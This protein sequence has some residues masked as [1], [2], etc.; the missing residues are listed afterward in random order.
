MEQPSSAAKK[1]P[2]FF[3]AIVFVLLALSFISL[4]QTFESFLKTGAADYLTIILSVSAI[5][6]SSYMVAQ[7]RRK[8]LKLGF[9]PF[10]VFT[11]VQ[12]SNCDFKNT[13]EF[14]SGDFIL[15]KAELCPKCSIPTFVSSIYRE[16]T[17]EEKK[18]Q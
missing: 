4:Y 13:R 11:T 2:Y 17:E 9:E 1:M 10:K 16:A 12:C 6:L 5:A 3:V 7:M 15:K 18:E 14:Q 8:P